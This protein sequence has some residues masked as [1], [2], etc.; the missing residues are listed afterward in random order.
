V[1]LLIP[2]KSFWNN[3]LN[4]ND[5][6]KTIREL[7]ENIEELDRTKDEL[8]I[9][10]I[11]FSPDV[12]LRWYFRDD[13][14]K[15]D[16]D[17]LKNIIDDYNYNRRILEKD[18]NSLSRSLLDTSVVIKNLLEE[19]KDLYKKMTPFIKISHYDDYINYIKS[20]TSI[21]SKKTEIDSSIIKKNEIINNKVWVIEERIRE[22]RTYLEDNLRLI[23]N[24]RLDERINIIAKNPWF[25]KL[26]NSRKIEILNATLEK[27]NNEIN[28]L[29]LSEWFLNNSI[30]QKIEIYNI[31]YRKLE[32]FRNSFIEKN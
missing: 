4:F 6:T 12:V 18:L 2:I 23:V 9:R 29:T 16:L 7:R 17:E 31:T 15:S 26:E 27:T 1:L 14:T 19:K 11:D 28:K 20:D 21:Y 3:D 24:Q 25:I 30:L 10:S 32:E 22:H 8:Y 5:N 13:L